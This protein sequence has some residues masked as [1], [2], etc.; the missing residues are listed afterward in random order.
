MILQRIRTS[1]L[2]KVLACM[3]T[4][5]L[6]VNVFQINSLFA[7][8]SG[9]SAPEFSSFTSIGVNDMVDPFSGNFG[10]NIPLFEVPGPN[11]SYPFNLAYQSDIKMDQEASW[12]GLG[13]SLNAGSIQR[14]VRGIPDDFNG[15]V[16]EKSLDMKPTMT[17]GASIALNYEL[18]GGDF[19]KLDGAVKKFIAAKDIKK[20]GLGVNLK[21][22]FN[23]KTGWGSGI[24]ANLTQLEKEKGSNNFFGTVGIN[25][26]S[27]NGSSISAN[28][29][30]KSENDVENK[31]YSAG[32]TLAS[33]SGLNYNMSYSVSGT[34]L[35][36]QIDEE[37]GK[38]IYV[39]GDKNYGAGLG[40]SFSFSSGS[41]A[42][43]V[44]YEYTGVNVSGTFKLD[45]S[46]LGS[47][48]GVSVQGFYN[49]QKLKNTNLSVK[50]Y[51]YLHLG[52]GTKNDLDKDHE[53][54][55]LDYDVEKG[56]MLGTSTP[57]LGTPK[58]QYD[59]LTVQGQ[60]A[61]GMFR[62]FRSDIG[63]LGPNSMEYAING[64]DFG[65]DGGFKKGGISGE[66]SRSVTK[67]MKYR[68][69]ESNFLK[70]H[71][72]IDEDQQ[73]KELSDYQTT[74]FKMHGEFTSYPA[75]QKDYIGGEEPIYVPFISKKGKLA[76]EFKTK[77]GKSLSFIDNN[78]SISSTD[79]NS[80]RMK[81]VTPITAF[82][83][84]EIENNLKYKVADVNY[85]ERTVTAG[86]N[87][88]ESY[89]EDISE[90]IGGYIVTKPDGTR[91]FYFLPSYN[92]VQ[93]EVMY[94]IPSTA[95][96]D[97]EKGTVTVDPDIKSIDYKHKG[98]DK[99]KSYTKTPAYA[100]SYLLTAIVGA[101]YVDVGNN[102]PDDNDLGYWVKLNYST[103]DSYAWRAPFKDA[104]YI[105]GQ[106]TFADDD[107]ATFSYGVREQYSLKSVETKTHKAVF[108]V[109]GRQ[110]AIG[111]KPYGGKDDNSESIRL[112]NIKLFSKKELTTPIKTVHFEYVDSDNCNSYCNA[113]YTGGEVL[114]CI[115][116]CESNEELCPG[117]YNHSNVSSTHGKLTLKRVFFTYGNSNRGMSTPYTF[118]Y[119]KINGQE[120]LANPDY[121]S[122]HIDRWG[123]YKDVNFAN[124]NPE[125]NK[126]YRDFPYTVQNET[127]LGITET[128]FKLLK[129]KEATA[130]Q[131]T[132]INLPSGGRIDVEYESD[133][134]AYVQHKQAN[135]M[136]FIESFTDGYLFHDKNRATQNWAKWDRKSA[137]ANEDYLT[138]YFKLPK[139][140]SSEVD[141][142]ESSK[143]TF[144]KQ[145]IKPLERE[146]KYQ[147]YFRV[148]SEL[149]DGYNE[150]IT[151]YADIALDSDDSPR[152][153]FV[154]DEDKLSDD[155]KCQ[156]GFI[157]LKPTQVNK[158]DKKKNREN[159]ARYY[160]PFAMAGWQF[161]RLN[162]MQLMNSN[163]ETTERLKSFENDKPKNKIKFLKA[164]GSAAANMLHVFRDY[165]K[166]AYKREFANQIIPEESMIRLACPNF[167][168][169]GNSEVQLRKYGGGTRV[170]QIK[171]TDNWK[172]L[173]QKNGTEFSDASYGQV[174][175]YTTTDKNGVTISSGVAQYEP[176][177]G[178]DENALR[179]AK[180]Y[181]GSIPFGSDNNLFYEYPINESLYPGAS[182]GY[183]KVTV[184]SLATTRLEANPESGITADGY[185]V[186][187]FYTAKDFPVYTKASNI[188][189]KNKNPFPV[190]VPFVGQSEYDIL[191]ASQGFVTVLNDMHG[192]MKSMSQYATKVDGDA[193]SKGELINKV[194]YYYKTKYL[195]L[196]GENCF[197]LDNLMPIGTLVSKDM[198][199]VASGKY[200]IL[201]NQEE[202]IM[203][204]EY[205]LIMEAK[206][207]QIHSHQEGVDFNADFVAF[208]PGLSFWPS[209]TYSEDELNTVVTNKIIYRA[210]ILKSTITHEK[211]N[212]VQKVD[213]KLFDME[214]G[215]VVMSTSLTGDKIN[216]SANGDQLQYSYTIP[217]YQQ[218]EY[219]AM[220]PADVNQNLI[221]PFDDYVEESEGKYSITLTENTSI[222]FDVLKELLVVGDEFIVSKESGFVANAYVKNI[223]TDGVSQID[224]TLL[225]DKPISGTGLFMKNVRSGNR[226]IL[227]AN[228]GNIVSLS[229]PTFVNNDPLN[230][231]G[232]K[233]IKV[234]DG[235]YC[236]YYQDC[237]TEAAEVFNNR[238]VLGHIQDFWTDEEI[239]SRINNRLLTG[240]KIIQER[241]YFSS[242]TYVSSFLSHFFSYDKVNSVHIMNTPSF[243]PKIEVD[244]L[245][246]SNGEKIVMYEW[247]EVPLGISVQVAVSNERCIPYSIS[248]VHSLYNSIEFPYIYFKWVKGIGITEIK[249]ASEFETFLPE[250]MSKDTYTNTFVTPNMSIYESRRITLS[251]YSNRESEYYDDS[252]SKDYL[253][254]D[255][256]LSAS[257][258]NFKPGIGV[259]TPQDAENITDLQ[260]SLLWQPKETYAYN[261]NRQSSLFSIDE[262][263]KKAGV[264]NWNE[265][266]PEESKALKLTNGVYEPFR[267]FIWDSTKLFNND[268]AHWI[269][270]ET[271]TKYAENGL[272]CESKNALGIYSCIYFNDFANQP[273]IV[274]QNAKQTQ[275]SYIDF[276]PETSDLTLVGRDHTVTTSL[277]KHSGDNA[278]IL[279]PNDD[280]FSR[281]FKFS[282]VKPGDVYVF[283]IWCKT[284]GDS[285]HGTFSVEP[286]CL[287]GQGCS[288]NW[289]INSTYE[290][291]KLFTLNYIVPNN[292]NEGNF[293]LIFEKEGN[294][295]ST[296]YFDDI[297]VFPENTS[298]QTYVYNNKDYKVSA[299]LDDNG[300]A[301]FYYYNEEGNL[302]L[303][304]KETEQGLKTIQTNVSHTSE[305]NK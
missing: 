227:A 132:N 189:I 123:N 42:P 236:E 22:Y 288:N 151:G 45:V 17:V 115:N 119:G 124:A 111:A 150:F 40:S 138:V 248:P 267:Y 104:M 177:A 210:G 70:K 43:E 240:S 27:Q 16:I 26:D 202:M 134:Y 1:K 297:R 172:A 257:A 214:T 295:N 171:I 262:T 113:N 122:T 12:V 72:F 196:D 83:N 255:N 139:K 296:F 30:L 277:E 142:E 44:P 88:G 301:S 140:V 121:E 5:N 207:N 265:M 216:N 286:K 153:G 63:V 221:I 195:S 65:F 215:A 55:M 101:D 206:H 237:Y 74:Y 205:E 167:G 164:I 147:I 233:Y 247:N 169:K 24:G 89:T 105:P 200:N 90:D 300:Y 261:E 258:M 186:N 271:I 2:S 144:I 155:N 158:L 66:Y 60:G 33:E 250:E 64:G 154:K 166:T 281:T 174:Y 152:C 156:Y 137:T 190:I 211:D 279:T 160:H 32:L 222:P 252:P 19:D 78:T 6:C 182:V 219:K 146:G 145:Y 203:G 260:K 283:Q 266:T 102:G 162:A 290:N 264:V 170:K 29:S 67:Q 69:L 128:E 157:L 184:K 112:D 7:L 77:S 218:K 199:D 21:L 225:S 52:A 18:F 61:Q 197:E 108:S 8:T 278:L 291:W 20:K 97:R 93:E 175:S 187:E 125:K 53:A 224:V 9:P 96:I 244:R 234:G 269:P 106:E 130:W 229:D 201:T 185:V 85:L 10:Y 284:E 285:P 191:S 54:R 192:K 39:K 168:E 208:L 62:A 276:E 254:L 141:A 114:D 217:A 241:E 23:N 73:N 165:T 181:P 280:S 34:F 131:L 81:T 183:S 212:L 180:P 92:L 31:N 275:V 4:I 176:I 198:E 303:V 25:S 204:E 268:A 47:A 28:L 292:Y 209:F 57:Y 161:V 238:L 75:S 110:D 116:K 294:Q 293:K 249:R 159:G 194:S 213:N 51:G 179:Y 46:I 3:L 14:N 48:P 253:S 36:K 35:E 71:Q 226:N 272:A 232:R 305:I 59:V 84:K 118:E 256:V 94:S 37:T 41:Y 126:D 188:S 79:N 302:Y 82:K 95:G 228:V 80:T 136:F 50:S 117:I 230:G 243:I 231:V 99:F 76:S 107:K 163:V 58:M 223:E 127:Q 49:K 274:A 245:S 235:G 282:D 273:F 148:K 246:M 100:T 87:G 135:Q 287:D 263:T 143:E 103:G 242:G 149:L 298:I 98:T 220:G 173:V 251:K 270:T 178:G 68:D 133:D 15:K 120:E 13:W 11:G 259:G 109:S 86:I 239:I 91:Y 289:T 38:E 193:V 304:K 129:Q 299:I 56:G